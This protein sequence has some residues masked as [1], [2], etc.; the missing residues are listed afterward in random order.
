MPLYS[1]R[2]CSSQATDSASRWFV[3]SSSS[4]R[5]GDCSS[6]RHS[7]T[8]RRSPPE[9]FDDVRVGRRQAQR[10]HRVLELRVEVPGAGRF[11]RVLHLR[12][13]LEDLVHLLGGQLLAELR[14]DLVEP[15]QQR[16]DGRHAFLDV[17]EDVLRRVE[18]GFL[19]Q[20][21]RPCSPPTARLAD[22]SP[23][24]GPP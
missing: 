10:V 6:S 22:D 5:S 21:S 16:A 14:V 12:L 1:C 7:A 3:G 2:K 23:G 19:R 9:S 13:L 11:D 15:G 18:R 17:A 24:R 4:S 20:D 8:R